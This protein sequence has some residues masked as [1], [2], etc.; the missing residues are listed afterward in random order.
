MMKRVALLTALL[1][2]SPLA[3][4]A[5]QDEAPVDSLALARQY[6]AWLY[7][8]VADSLV[9]HS[10]EAARANFSTP[11]RW[12]QYSAT[13]LERGGFEVEVLEE[14]WKLRNGQ[15]Q[16]WRIASFSGADEPLLVR[17]VLNEEGQIVA[18]GLGSASQPPMV[19]SETC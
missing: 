16:Y 14:T 2:L 4:A 5:A 11:E 17:W 9:A 10:S 18:I 12:A 1:S 19:E 8:A 15:C 6:T 3:R 7:D 13:I